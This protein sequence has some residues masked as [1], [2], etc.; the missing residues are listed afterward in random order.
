MRVIVTGGNGK[1]GRAVVAH[2]K[3]TGHDVF[4]FDRV[5]AR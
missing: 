2:L 5:A 3:E 1:L 4:V